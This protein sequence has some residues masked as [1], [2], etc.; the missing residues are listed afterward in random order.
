MYKIYKHTLLVG[1]HKDWSYIGQ[2]SLDNPNTRW[3]NGYGYKRCIPF[4]GAIKKYGWE[5]FS[6]E[7]IEDNIATL[8]EANKREAYWIQYYH[9]WLDDPECRGYNSTLGGNNFLSSEVKSKISKSLQGH[10]VT[11]EMRKIFSENLKAGKGCYKYWQ[12]KKRSAE[13]VEKCRQASTGKIKTAEQRAKVTDSLLKYYSDNKNN[14]VRADGTKLCTPVRCV[15]TGEVFFST[16]EASRQ[17]S[18]KH[19]TTGASAIRDAAKGRCKTAYGYHWEY[20]E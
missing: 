16:N 2:T 6:H 13:T 8:E 14:K 7:I 9:T 20:L 15:E 18:P 17:K 11:D 4:Y 3:Q 12:G 5:N 10:S 1:E 19:T